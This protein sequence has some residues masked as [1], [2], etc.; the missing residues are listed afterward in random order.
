MENGT[1]QNVEVTDELL[2]NEDDLDVNQMEAIHEDLTQLMEEENISERSGKTSK[3]RLDD[4]DNESWEQV[5]NRKQRMR[6]VRGCVELCIT[7]KDMFPKQFALAKLFKSQDISNIT[8]VKYI[9]PFKIN[10]ELSKASAEQ[11]MNCE[12]FAEMGWRFQRPYEVELSYGVIKDIELELTEEDLLKAMSCSTEICNVRRL[13]RRNASESTWTD[14]ESIRVGFKGPT[15]PSHLCIYDM[16]VKVEPYVFP[17]TQCTRCWRYGHTHRMCPSKKSYCPKCAGKHETCEV[18]SYKCLNCTD[19][20]MAMNKSCPIY[21]K[22][23]RIRDIMAEF[24][25]SYR[26]AMA[27]YTPPAVV[28]VVVVE[29]LATLSQDDPPAMPTHPAISRQEPSVPTYAQKASTSACTQENEPMQTEDIP[30]KV[31]HNKKKNKRKTK[32]REDIFCSEPQSDVENCD[33]FDEKDQSDTEQ[34]NETR[35]KIDF[36]LHRLLSKLK[37]IVFQRDESFVT[38]IHK[39][40]QTCVQHLIS[41]IFQNI[42]D[43]SFLLK[44]VN[45]Y[46]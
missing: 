33:I 32:N 27:I 9:N 35:Q 42:S 40:V 23:K 14:C 28:P 18:T 17:V 4:D 15:L 26:K 45:D 43:W 10:I 39:T 8:K 11:L 37:N 16:R 30:Q 6:E 12:H 21:I 25:C 31:Q 1:I 2:R 29:N 3:R 36:S 38:K 19:K 24:N 20:H 34:T 46:G 44:I 7:S 5:M 22:E 41:W 13:K